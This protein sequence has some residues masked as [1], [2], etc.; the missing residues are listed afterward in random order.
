MITKL[1]DRLNKEHIFVHPYKI[2]VDGAVVK[3][4]L[5]GVGGDKWKVSIDN[6]RI[7]IYG[8]REQ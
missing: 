6:G 4:E 5:P 3:D 1:T 2:I 7:Q 8:K